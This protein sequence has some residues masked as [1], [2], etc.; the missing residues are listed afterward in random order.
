LLGSPVHIVLGR[1]G[2]KFQPVAAWVRRRAWRAALAHGDESIV[3]IKRQRA[4]DDGVNHREDGG[5]GA[6]PERQHDQR[7]SREGRGGTERAQRG[8]QVVSHGAT[9]QLP[10][11]PHPGFSSKLALNVTATG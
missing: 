4:Q 9:S 7:D 11:L 1:D 6:D 10:R 3:L 2:G 8:F 5:G